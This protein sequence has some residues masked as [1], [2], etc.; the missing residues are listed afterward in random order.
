MP[1]AEGDEVA[2]LITGLGA[3]SSEELYIL[4]HSVRKHLDAKGVKTYKTGVGEYATSMEMAGA[5]I[6]IEKLD[7]EL[8]GYL[9]YPVNTPFICQK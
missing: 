3:T 6:S 2:V 1:L 7:D 5:S 4:A 8:K 9:D